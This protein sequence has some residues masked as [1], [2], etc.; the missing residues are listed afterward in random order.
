MWQHVGIVRRKCKL[1]LVNFPSRFL[2]SIFLIFN[3][4]PHTHTNFVACWTAKGTQNRL[5]S[6]M[7]FHFIYSLSLSLIYCRRPHT[8]QF[9]ISL[10]L[11]LSSHINTGLLAVF[12]LKC[13]VIA[14]YSRESTIWISWITYWACSDHHRKMTWIA[15]S[16][17]KPAAT[18]SHYHSSRKYHG[19]S[20]SRKPIKRPSICSAKC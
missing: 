1:T 13:S 14:R 7:Y 3:I 2:S 5:I 6:G 16:T 20:S 11:S 18:F 9:F 12:W 15:L 17:R 19:T 10:N 8:K 4:F